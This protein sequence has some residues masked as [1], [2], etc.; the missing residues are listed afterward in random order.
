MKRHASDPK[1]KRGGQPGNINAC[2]RH[3]AG[4]VG[5]RNALKH[6]AYAAL[7]I[8]GTDPEEAAVTAEDIAGDPVEMTRDVLRALNVQEIRL[9]QYIVKLRRRIADADLLA[10]PYSAESKGTP[11]A[12]TRHG[13]RYAVPLEAIAKLEGVLDLIHSRK[14]KAL[15][16]IA[17]LQLE[18]DKAAGADDMAAA[19]LGSGAE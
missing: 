11:T 16:T 14:L 19:W 3:K 15:E 7:P 2:G 4:P 10:S 6:G 1:R 18:R 9:T 8:L 17:V 13:R 12:N 5:N